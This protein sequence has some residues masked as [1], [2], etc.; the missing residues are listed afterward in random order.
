M[1][2]LKNYLGNYK[3]QLKMYN[4]EVYNAID[5]ELEISKTDTIG[6]YNYI[7]KYLVQPNPDIRNYKFVSH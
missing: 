6:V 3:G 7:I 4:P 2:C 1:K 5:M